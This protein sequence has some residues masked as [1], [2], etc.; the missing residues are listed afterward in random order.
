LVKNSWGPQWGDA[1]FIKIALKDGAG[2]C[3]IN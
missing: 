3:G 1:G 2:I